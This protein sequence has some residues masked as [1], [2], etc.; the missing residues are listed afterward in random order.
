M[1]K[2]ELLNGFSKVLRIGYCDLQDLTKYCKRI[3]YNS[4]VYGWNWD[5]FILNY[6]IAICTGYRGMT[7]DN[8]PAEC[9]KE[10]KEKIAE[11]E[12]ENKTGDWHK[13]SD[14]VRNATLE[15]LYKYNIIAKWMK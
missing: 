13:K 11:I 10:I 3:G 4:G 15:I 2:R 6:D 1:T 14:I 5:A 12:K 8:I 9:E 7:G